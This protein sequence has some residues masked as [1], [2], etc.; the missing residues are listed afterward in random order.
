MLISARKCGAS[1]SGSDLGDCVSA[2]PADSSP[3]LTCLLRSNEIPLDSELPSIHSI[4]S[5]GENRLAAVDIE[6]AAVRARLAQ[7][8]Q[9]RWQI[10]KSIR[11]HRAV[12]SA[13]RRM[14]PELICE[15]FAWTLP[16]DTSARKPPWNLGWICRS[17]RLWALEYPLLWSCISIPSTD[18]EPSDEMPLSCMIE[19]QIERSANAPLDIVWVTSRWASI[20]IPHPG[21][22]QCILPHCNR[23]RSLNVI[24]PNPKAHM[25]DWLRPVTGH[26]DGLERLEVIQDGHHMLL[27]IPPFFA[28][29]P[30][31]HEVVLTD[32]RLGCP[33]PSV[34]LPWVQ[35]TYY[36][37]TDSFARQLQVMEAA[38]NLLE[39]VLR[40]DSSVGDGP[41]RST[42]I[43]LAQL[44]RLPVYIPTH[45]SFSK[46]PYW[47]PYPLIAPRK[48]TY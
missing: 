26:L 5:D 6:I 38:P 40:C 14:P 23:W 35:I 12:I 33:S 30:R 25:L 34:E 41:A 29:A 19:C 24:V 37:G 8:T 46:H 2:E 21:V 18:T 9:T 44:R 45:S 48:Q 4:I 36:R 15:I 20:S 1:S 31:L 11:E 22:L 47:T 10:N 42:R 43:V 28:N 7:L 13:L 3:D 16:L 27:D 32:T 17:W 39:C